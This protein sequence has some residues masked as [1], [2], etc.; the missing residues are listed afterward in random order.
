MRVYTLYRITFDSLENHLS[1]AIT[2]TK[3]GVFAELSKLEECLTKEKV[4]L[5]LGW[6]IE[7]YPQFEIEEDDVEGEFK[8]CLQN[9][10]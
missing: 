7:V 6:N 8:K 1:N 3:M 10:Q 2:R 4:S 9:V 5:H